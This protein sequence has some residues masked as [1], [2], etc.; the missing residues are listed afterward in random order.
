MKA[1]GSN[2]KKILILSRK[3]A[4]PIFP[5]IKNLFIFPEMEIP[6]SNI[7]KFPKNPALFTPSSKNKIN[8]PEENI[9]Y[10][11]KQKPRKKVPYIFRK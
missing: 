7:K 11:R 10:F 6:S 3:E 8:P 1:F 4:F 2:I 5:E 9:S